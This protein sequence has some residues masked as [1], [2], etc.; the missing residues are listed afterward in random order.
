MTG[1][2]KRASGLALAAFCASQAFGQG[3]PQLDSK[4]PFEIVRS[5][6]AVQDQ[7]VRG[8]PGARA[9]LPK[10]IQLISE[11]LLARTRTFGGIRETPALR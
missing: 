8:N 1:W 5:M 3:E 4:Q 2:A 6:Q 11:R 7:V 9:K 10:L